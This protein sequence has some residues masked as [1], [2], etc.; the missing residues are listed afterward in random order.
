MGAKSG[1]GV[2]ELERVP[3]SDGFISILPPSGDLIPAIPPAAPRSEPGILDPF[4]VWGLR[5]G[6]SP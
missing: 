5:G 4:L 2:A 3:K 6:L 1:C